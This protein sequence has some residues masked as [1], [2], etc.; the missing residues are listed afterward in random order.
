MPV[1]V[2]ICAGVGFYMCWCWFL[3]VPVLVSAIQAQTALVE[4][5]HCVLVLLVMPKAYS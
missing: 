5:D 3:Y 1:L 4:P 2:S